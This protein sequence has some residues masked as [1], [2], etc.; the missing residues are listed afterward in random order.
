[1]F[2]F[3]AYLAL[4]YISWRMA[5]SKLDGATAA[6]KDALDLPTATEDRTSPI[7]FGE[8]LV[9][10][11]VLWY[12][13]YK[14]VPVEKT[15][16]VNPVKTAKQV[17]GHNYC[18]G[19]WQSVSGTPVD[20]ITLFKVGER[21]VWSGNTAIDNDTA[22]GPTSVSINVSAT[23]TDTEG[24][25]LPDGV[26]GTLR[27]LN[28]SE[29]EV[30][31]AYT[32]V[33]GDNYLK[34]QVEADHPLYPNT[35]H[36]VWL[37]PS[38]ATGGTATPGKPAATTG[39]IGISPRPAA[40]KFGVRRMPKT[41][42]WM[43]FG[44][45]DITVSYGAMT[46][47]AWLADRGNVVGDA[48]PAFV[49]AELLTSPLEAISGPRLTWRAIN[50]NSFLR[51]A[52]RLKTE[53]HGVS[54]VIQEQTKLRTVV[55]EVLRQINGV[56]DEDERTGQVSLRLL[57]EDDVPVAT[58]N[59]SNIT[60]LGGL[61]RQTLDTAPNEIIVPFT[62]RSLNYESRF[63]IAQ[64]STAFSMSG[65]VIS[66]ERRFIGV[67]N[68]AL[69][70]T[71][72]SR[73]LRMMSTSLARLRLKAGIPPDMVLKPGHLVIVEHPDNGQVLRMRIL[74][75]RYGSYQS[76]NE[77]ELELMED[78]FRAG[79]GFGTV[80]V[81]P[82]VLAPTQ[83]ATAAV[84]PQLFPAPY[85]FTGSDYDKLMYIG[86]AFDARTTQLQ[87]A[88]KEGV[89]SWS[90]SAD[91]LYV[92]QRT[93]PVISGT[94]DA[95]L[96]STAYPGSVVLSLSS[97]AMAAYVAYGKANG[98]YVLA[99]SEWLYSDSVSINTTTN[100]LTLSVLERGIFDTVPEAHAAGKKFVLMVDYGMD[101]G[102]PMTLTTD[103]GATLP[104][105]S[106]A[107][108][109]A[110]SIGPGGWLLVDNAA[111]SQ[112]VFGYNAA[113]SKAQ[114]PL[115]VG[116]VRM[117]FSIGSSD[118]VGAPN[119]ISRSSSLSLTWVNRSRLTR[120]RNPYFFATEGIEAGQFVKY[121]AF[122]ENDSGGWVSLGSAVST[123]AGATSASISMA[124]VPAGARRIRVDMQ[125]SRPNAG[126]NISSPV[127]SY[128]WKLSS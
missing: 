105:Y 24:Q 41:R 121:S 93:R 43:P 10:P 102:Q 48:N 109:R 65:S 4:T 64:N 3:F 110:D 88:L 81:S 31:V 15:V 111:E 89:S 97:T 47:A 5:P 38:S 122:Y 60:W 119:N 29:P 35:T 36:F 95:A 19:M 128:Y 57:R 18:L 87:P 77:V 106:S 104:G 67:S 13:D 52:D 62:D 116:L 12:G 90:A 9:T 16:R 20:A 85:A 80:T 114:R 83:P 55:G 112:A 7:A 126:G 86:E 58:F 1:M 100:K 39:S 125:S 22:F 123:A 84:S 72:A 107:V 33:H 76:R 98:L 59:K 92:P 37:G 17:I 117:D 44:R 34:A 113:S 108:M 66:Q 32:S 69:A 42:F 75:A 28:Y 56:L 68:A 8:C 25:E 91:T 101:E 103:A 54:F 73:E 26:N 94:L 23:W 99:G 63:A 127:K 50:A 45:N 115:P 96:A 79:T 49:I 74:N 78:I 124:T 118:S 40:W 21:T 46:Q 71:L 11:A 6:S 61:S 30:P 27:F 82:V 120:A 14:P 53:K 70:Q 51:A 2:N